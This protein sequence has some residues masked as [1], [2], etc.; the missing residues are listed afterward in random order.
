MKR[1][2]IRIENGFRSGTVGAGRAQDS[3]TARDGSVKL[4]HSVAAPRLF[5]LFN[6]SYLGL[7]PQAKYLSPLRGSTTTRRASSVGSVSKR[8]RRDRCIAWGVS[9][10]DRETVGVKEILSWSD[11]VSAA[12]DRSGCH[13]ERGSEATLHPVIPTEGAKRPSGG[14]CESLVGPQYKPPHR[15]L[16]SLRSLGMTSWARE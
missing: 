3:V 6:G 8:R 16:D 13:P 11:S 7:T 4:N 1:P 9:P 2:A 15:S 12:L 14:I 5:F 10:R